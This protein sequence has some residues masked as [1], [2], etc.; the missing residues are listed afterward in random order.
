[1]TTATASTI[2]EPTAADGKSGVGLSGHLSQV[3]S[4]RLANEEYGLDIMGVQ[5]IILMGEITEIP[6]VPDYVRGLINLR[7]KVIPIVDLRK[8]F[9]LEAG[10]TTEHT[11]IIVFNSGANT[12]GIVVDAVNEVL[13]LEADQ[14]E[15]PPK[16]V[17]GID[18]AYIK[19]LVKMESRIMILLDADG[20]MSITDQDV[21]SA[22]SS[23]QSGAQ[24]DAGGS[25][26]S[27]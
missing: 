9:A 5:E 12:F 3:V 7:G 25:T 4:F 8:R 18:S 22:A 26:S 14:I 2:E 16:G 19:G 15:P 13:R 1:M 6:E 24:Q 17:V 27:D 20:I 23:E 10:E 21:I 11:R